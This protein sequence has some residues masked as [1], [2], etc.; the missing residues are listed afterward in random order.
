MAK[1]AKARPKKAAKKQT[2]KKVQP[3]PKGYHSVTAYLSI[4]DA[5]QA[6]EF[7]KKAFGAKEVLRMQGPDG[8]VGHAEIKIGD[9]HVMMADESPN[10]GF[11]GPLARGGTTVQMMIY[12]RDVDGT[13]D[14]AVAA[15]GKLTRPVQN[16]FYGDRSG[17][18]EDP[19][20]HVWTIATHV[21]DV[22]PAEM[23]RRSEEAMKKMASGG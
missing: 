20:G 23:R 11:L 10:M 21:E 4:R 7:Y 1:K 13:V 8:K 5:A 3:I 12:V 16:Q 22:P 9:S 15:G 19:F 2:T 14:K 17:T 6:L 18:I